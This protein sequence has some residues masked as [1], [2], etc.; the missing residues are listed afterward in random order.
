LWGS[1]P[2]GA[3]FTVLTPAAGW[4]RADGWRSRNPVCSRLVGRAPGRPTGPLTAQRAR[5]LVQEL[6]VRRSKVFSIVWIRIPMKYR[7]NQSAQPGCTE[8][9][10]SSSDLLVGYTRATQPETQ[11]RPSRS[12]I[13]MAGPNGSARVRRVRTHGDTEPS[14]GCRSA[15]A[16]SCA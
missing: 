9:K 12:L 7:S 10:S 15:L 11:R 2:S 5:I 13:D 6:D 3:Q 1:W 14:L 4:R 16:F 8:V